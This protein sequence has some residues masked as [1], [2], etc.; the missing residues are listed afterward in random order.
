MFTL[1]SCASTGTS[2]ISVTND[3]D[4]DPF[5]PYNRFMFGVNQIVYDVLLDPITYA[6]RAATPQ[7]FRIAMRNVFSNLGE[8]LNAVNNALQGDVTGMRD[9]VFRFIVN[10]TYGMAGIN[11]VASDFG[12]PEDNQ[13]FGKT[14]AV[15]GVSEGPYVV[16]PLIGGQNLRD[17][18]GIAG[19]FLAGPFTWILWDEE[20]SWYFMGLPNIIVVREEYIDYANGLRQSSVDYYSAMREALRQNRKASVNKALGI[21]NS[22]NLY[23][24]DFEEEDY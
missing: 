16:L 19:D 18:F 23:D 13:D 17:A 24:F 5:E 1:S 9:N 12:L 15:W 20:N 6:Y 21:D 14:L 4:N 8:P 10:S 3:E 7:G 22:A 2:G 11:D